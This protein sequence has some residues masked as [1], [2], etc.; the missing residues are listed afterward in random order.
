MTAKYRITER[1]TSKKGIGPQIQFDSIEG[2]GTYL[3]NWS[4]HLLR[5]PEEAIQAGHSPL[6]DV[7]ANE[8]L[9]VTKLSDNPYLTRAKARLLAA[10]QDLEV[11]F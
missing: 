6:M 2:P 3:C 9:F 5:V 7:V 1:D 10:D 8:P 4:G 11:N